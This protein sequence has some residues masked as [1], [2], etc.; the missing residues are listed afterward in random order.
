MFFKERYME[1][2]SNLYC[3]SIMVFNVHVLLFHILLYADDYLEI[4]MICLIFYIKKKEQTTKREHQG[5]KKL[6]EE[7]SGSTFREGSV[8]SLMC[9]YGPYEA[10]GVKRPRNSL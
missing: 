6:Q 9:P 5:R 10:L 1:V 4:E 3:A 7:W 2:K 8:R